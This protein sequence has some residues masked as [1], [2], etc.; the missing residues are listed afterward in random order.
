MKDREPKQHKRLLTAAG[1]SVAK[2]VAIDLFAQRRENRTLT[3]GLIELDRMD[4]TG[5]LEGFKR[6]A[7]TEIEVFRSTDL[8]CVRDAALDGVVSGVREEALRGPIK[9][10][11]GKIHS[12]RRPNS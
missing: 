2:A 4:R 11:L 8:R 12:R 7:R 10:A 5:R 1:L 9:L 6:F 3:K